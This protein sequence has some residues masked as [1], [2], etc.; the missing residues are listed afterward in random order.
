[1][2]TTGYAAFNDTIN[3]NIPANTAATP[4]VSSFAGGLLTVTGN[5]LSPSSYILVN[6]LRGDIKTY[7]SSSIIYYAPPLITTNSQN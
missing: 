3:V 4:L 2:T 5:N 7:S 6:G 1:L